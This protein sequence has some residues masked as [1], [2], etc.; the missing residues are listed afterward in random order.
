MQKKRSSIFGVLESLRTVGK[1]IK[2]YLL[3]R[4]SV[5]LYSSQACFDPMIYT[6]G[7]LAV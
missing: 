5:T 1:K 2:E 6:T 7:G 4:H 3:N